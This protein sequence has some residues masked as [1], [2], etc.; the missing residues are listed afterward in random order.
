MTDL[1]FNEM[2]FLAQDNVENVRHELG[3]TTEKDRKRRAKDLQEE[4]DFFEHAK[5]RLDGITKPSSSLIPQQE[6]KSEPRSQ[7]RVSG[8][9]RGGSLDHLKVILPSQRAPEVPPKAVEACD[10]H[11]SSQ[12]SHSG[13]TELSWPASPSSSRRR[14]ANQKDFVYTTGPSKSPIPESALKALIDTG[15][16][17]F[18]RLSRHGSMLGSPERR[19]SHDNI[20]RGRAEPAQY[21]D[22]G[23]MVSPWSTSDQELQDPQLASHAKTTTPSPQ[24][25]SAISTQ[26]K[27]QTI[28]VRGEER[29]KEISDNSYQVGTGAEV[30]AQ[31]EFR[32][33]STGPQQLPE[34][35]GSGPNEEFR[36]RYRDWAALDGLDCRDDHG[37]FGNPSLTVCQQQDD[38]TDRIP[39]AASHQQDCLVLQDY[40]PPGLPGL[41]LPKILPSLA[42]IS[43]EISESQRLGQ[44][45][46]SYGL[47]SQRVDCIGDIDGGLAPGIDIA[48]FSQPVVGQGA[49]T[50]EETMH[51][52]I[53]RIEAEVLG[54]QAGLPA[55][56]E[57][58]DCPQEFPRQW[59]SPSQVESNLVD[60]K[61]IC[62]DGKG[63]GRTATWGRRSYLLEGSPLRQSPAPSF[64]GGYMSEFWKPNRLL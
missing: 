14:P 15:V 2:E 41:C 59:A 64:S 35:S 44:S 13:S 17:D 54:R 3:K 21:E 52:F 18:A 50:F 37:D 43:Q 29:A 24:G 40:R 55:W 56:A 42:E 60:P 48:Q 32:S 1:A 25:G 47:G 36:A 23:I 34:S 51:D 45:W 30:S 61:E 11:Q 8:M 58:E 57:S 33:S 22:K 10:A 12:E 27:T 46:G 49:E 31:P 62:H 4:S 38:V 20:T 53:E 5:Q 28:E 39:S 19:S 9:V 26:L 16:F 6:P 7:V 63:A